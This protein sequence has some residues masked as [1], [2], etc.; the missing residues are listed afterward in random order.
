MKWTWDWKRDVFIHVLE[1]GRR[2]YREIMCTKA[3]PGEALHAESNCDPGAI[4][5]SPSLMG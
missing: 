5:V 1:E 2:A 3:R 4:V